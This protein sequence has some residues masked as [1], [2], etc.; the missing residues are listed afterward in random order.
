MKATQPLI[1]TTDF[2]VIYRKQLETVQVNLG[3][4][5]NQAC[6]HCHVNAGPKRKELMELETVNQVLDL[7]ERSKIGI[8]DMTGGAPEMNPHFRYLVINAR[9]Q[10]VH[11]IDR[12]NLTILEEPGYED[13]HTFLADHQVE[14]T[15]SLPCYIEDNVNRQRGDGVF[16]SSIRAIKKLN[17]LGYGQAGSRLKLNL[18]YNPQGATLPPNQAEL[19]AAYHHELFEHFGIVFNQLFALANVP[20]QRFSNSLAA[21]GQLHDYMAL[22]KSAHRIE[23]L[24]AV[25]C[26]SLISIDWQGYVH[27]CD[28]NQMLEL[29][30]GD[31]ATKR[32]ITEINISE[33]TGKTIAIDDHCYACTA[34]S[35]SSC[36]GALKA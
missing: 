27:D 24:D 32:H 4:L 3:Y 20:I 9:N 7:M 29:P 28:F 22:L 13:L 19:E 30:L 1:K 33:L 5:C 2:P 18:V 15:A 25:M 36:R 26:R 35:G 34:G 21:K 6:R 23:N 8:L 12:C 11:V 31:S 17:T 10:G 16:E 14:I